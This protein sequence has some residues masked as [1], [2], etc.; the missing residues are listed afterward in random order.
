V[1][2]S[3]CLIWLAAKI[4]REFTEVYTLNNL[5]DVLLLQLGLKITQE[6]Y[7]RF[8]SDKALVV[9][10]VEEWRLTALAVAEA[11]TEAGGPCPGRR[12]IPAAHLL[13]DPRL[14]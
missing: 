7:N 12:W 3:S 13:A 2:K 6:S 1:V 9:F 8:V 11:A 4:P 5:Y 10:P 14:L